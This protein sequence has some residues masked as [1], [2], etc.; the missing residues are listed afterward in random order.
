MDFVNKKAF[1]GTLLAH[2]DGGVPNMLLNVPELS[3][4][5]FGYYGLLL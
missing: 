4:Y 3:A 5:Y 2:N 1:Q